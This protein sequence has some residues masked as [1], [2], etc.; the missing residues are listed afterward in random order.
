LA[1]ENLG[2]GTFKVMDLSVQRSGGSVTSFVRNSN[3]HRRFMRRFFTRTGYRYEMFNYLGEWHSHPRFPA[4]PSTADLRQMQKLIED[5]RQQAHFLV[6]LVIKLGRNGNL[7]GS[8][9]A[10]RRGQMPIKVRLHLPLHV[11]AEVTA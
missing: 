11:D 8:A 3:V 4:E 6:L 2:D 5:R 10:F 9:H 1:A 7:E